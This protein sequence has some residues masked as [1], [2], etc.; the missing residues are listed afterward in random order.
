MDLHFNIS[1]LWDISCTRQESMCVKPETRVTRAENIS[2]LILENSLFCSYSLRPFFFPRT[3]RHAKW[4]NSSYFEF[5]QKY[6]EYYSKGPITLFT[7]EELTTYSKKERR[8]SNAPSDSEMS[9]DFSL[10]RSCLKSLAQ[11]PKQDNKSRSGKNKLDLS[12]L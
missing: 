7:I 4:F 10:S 6:T 11:K 12:K 5:S 2:G 9:R 3:V 1:K 8:S